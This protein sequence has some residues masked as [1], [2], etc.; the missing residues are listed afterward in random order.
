MSLAGLA[1]QYDSSDS[2]EESDGSES[3]DHVQNAETPRQAKMNEYCP[4]KRPRTSSPNQNH[5]SSKLQLPERD[6]V[7]KGAIISSTQLLIASAGLPPSSKR[8]RE[9]ISSSPHPPPPAFAQAAGEAFVEARHARSTSKP[10]PSSSVHFLPPQVRMKRPNLSTE[11]L[12][13]YGCK[14]GPR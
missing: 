11:D 8:T 12:M 9:E 1:D 3:V 4:K 6:S 5:A 13:L 7:L 14:Q 10:R 2:S